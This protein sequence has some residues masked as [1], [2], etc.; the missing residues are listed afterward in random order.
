MFSLDIFDYSGHLICPI[1]TNDVDSSGQATDVVI[2][3]QRNGAKNLS[4]NLPDKMINNNGES[5]DNFRIE[6]QKAD[7]LIRAYDS[8]GELET[9]YDSQG[10]KRPV[11]EDYYIISEPKIVHQNL[12]AM[13]SVTCEHCSALLRTKNLGLVFSDTEGN[14]VGTAKDIL[15]TILSDPLDNSEP[16]GTGWKIGYVENFY[17]EYDPPATRLKMR[18]LVASDRT[19]AFNLISKLA[20]LFE[21]KPLYH[22]DTHTV[23][24][25]HMNPFSEPKDDGLPDVSTADGVFELNYGKNIKNVT[26]TVNTDNIVTH[27]YAYG[28]YGDNVSKYCG[29]DELEH[30]EHYFHASNTIPAGTECMIEAED[31][32]GINRIRYFVP[33][34]DILTGQD[35]IWST[36]DYASMSYVWIPQHGQVGLAYNV[37]EQQQHS[38]T[39][40]SLTYVDTFK[41]KNLV[42]S[43][44]NFNYYADVGL[45]TDEHLQTVAGYQR[46]VAALLDIVN[47]SSARMS[48]HISELSN[49]IG[50]VDFVKLKNPLFFEDDGE[51]GY[52]RV[53]YEKVEYT[54]EYM[55]KEKDWFKWR[56]AEGFLTK[57]DPKNGDAS[58]LYIVRQY[59]DPMTFDKHYFVDE[60]EMVVENQKTVESKN[61]HAWHLVKQ[62]NGMTR[63]SMAAYANSLLT[64]GSHVDISNRP[65]I[66][67]SEMIS[68]GWTDVTGDPVALYSVIRGFGT[69]EYPYTVLYTPINPFGTVYTPDEAYGYIQYC[70]NNATSIAEVMSRDGAGLIMAVYDGWI[71]DALKYSYST[72]K[73]LHTF[74]RMYETLGESDIFNID[75]VEEEYKT[76][77]MD[78][79]YKYLVI[80]KEWE[81]GYFDD[82]SKV[83]LFSSNNTN[84]YIGAAETSYLTNLAS[85]KDST[86]DGTI[87]HPTY[88]VSRKDAETNGQIDTSKL[89]PAGDNADWYGWCWVHDQT[90]ERS[91]MYFSTSDRDNKLWI[92]V[93][94]GRGTP[95]APERIQYFYNWREKVLYYHANGAEGWYKYESP[96]EIRIANLFGIVL[97]SAWTY[98][99]NFYGYNQ[100]YKYTHNADLAAGNYT[101]LTPYGSFLCF[102]TTDTVYVTPPTATAQTFPLIYDTT[103]K[104]VQTGEYDSSTV[105]YKTET[106]GFTVAEYHPTNAA[107]G[108]RVYNNTHLDIYGNDVEMDGW[109]TTHFIR[110]YE[111]IPYYV[112]KTSGRI[113]FYTQNNRFISYIDFN[114]LNNHQFETVEN[115]YYIRLACND[116]LSD[117]VVH[118]YNY[119]NSFIFKEKTYNLLN[120]IEGKGK[121]KGIIP[122]VKD[123][124]FLADYIYGSDD[125]CDYKI[126]KEAQDAVTQ[127]ENR[128]ADSLGYMYRD[129]WWQKN[130]Y[131]DGDEQKLYYDAMKTL[132]H[133]A[134]PEEKYEIGFLDT[135][136]SQQTSLPQNITTQSAAHLVDVDTGISKWA[137]IDKISRCYDQPWK[138]SIAINTNLTVMSQHTFADVLQHIAEVAN[139]MSGNDILYGRA[140]YVTSFGKI[141]ANQIEGQLQMDK[142][143]ITSASSTMYTDDRGNWVFEASDG[144]SAMMITGAG[145]CLAS[146]KDDDGEWVWRTF[147]TGEGFSADMITSGHIRAG[148]IE[149]GTI[150][151]SML[152]APVGSELELYGNESVRI[153]T[154]NAIASTEFSNGAN[155]LRASSSMEFPVHDGNWLIN[156]YQFPNNLPSAITNI[157]FK[158]HIRT[159]VGSK[160]KAAVSFDKGQTFISDQQYIDGDGWSTITAKIP[161]GASIVGAYIIFEDSN[162]DCYYHSPKLEYG[163]VS[164]AYSISQDDIDSSTRNLERA[165][166]DVNPKY[167]SSSVSS[168]ET[169]GSTANLYSELYDTVATS[170][171]AYGAI[172]K[173]NR[174]GVTINQI[175]SNSL[176]YTIRLSKIKEVDDYTIS[177]NIESTEAC[178]ITTQIN[179]NLQTSVVTIAPYELT[180]V[181]Y[182][183]YNVSLLQTNQITFTVSNAAIV[184]IDSL[185][186]EKGPVASA[187]VSNGDADSKASVNVLPNGDFNYYLDGGLL[188][189]YNTWSKVTNISNDDIADAFIC[190]KNLN[191]YKQMLDATYVSQYCDQN[192]N[193]L[194]VKCDDLTVDSSK[195]IG[196]K[197]I[198][199]AINEG[200]HYVLSMYAYALNVTKIVIQIMENNEV[201]IA[202]EVTNIQQRSIHN[203]NDYMRIEVPFKAKTNSCD[204]F[205]LAYCDVGIAVNSIA[206]FVANCKLEQGFFATPFSSCNLDNSLLN[207]ATLEELSNLKSRV[208]SAEFKVSPENII[209]T[210]TQ[211]DE[212]K[213]GVSQ[214]ASTIV[215]QKAEGITTQIKS[216]NSTLKNNNVVEKVSFFMITQEG[217]RI[218]KSDSN[219]S[220]LLSNERLSFFDNSQEVAYISNNTLSIT[221][222]Q[223]KQ[224]LEIGDLTA[225]VYS[226]GSVNIEWK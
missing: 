172:D 111:N 4:F 80:N 48:D 140:K 122:L 30:D 53:V 108:V 225:Y 226:D 221:Q 91:A 16:S 211:S 155:L 73:A 157:S 28:S 7:Y 143:K 154:E 176:T 57:G 36:L 149:S 114:A 112:N 61:Y 11:Y 202:K 113:C 150:V 19:G 87:E 171:S 166:L 217:L 197:H 119:D 65:E 214:E 1:Y 67:A 219:F 152:A 79:T 5:V 92:P 142:L 72:A 146:S 184:T 107:E 210:V 183:A 3:T 178:T 17:E 100:Q 174:H 9:A 51:Q 201:T 95:A 179:N 18:T 26:K 75:L 129:G 58:V 12:S 85:L 138:T 203:L 147:G 78:G 161:S 42:S 134:Y 158:V 29:I 173:N 23:D 13:R 182:P 204:I 131:V 69:E 186:V 38:G 207:G 190:G 162:T 191:E 165:I 40:I 192:V 175:G 212:F 56:K 213:N 215:D 37:Y 39:P 208:Q 88:F 128:M 86:K 77:V 196:V 106:K 135:R 32:F 126:L 98:S 117:L 187:W 96:A 216:I 49:I 64:P 115:T 206:L 148:L 164:T 169:F 200:S 21:A 45:F 20:D 50:S 198:P 205:I 195:Y 84:G 194:V 101:F 60:G 104:D 163:E 185:L 151:T 222:A 177:F 27:L 59:A 110:V 160:A 99:K 130:D 70:T 31:Y 144:S 52:T 136:E 10:L 35:I 170:S 116:D 89:P 25:V 33:T 125:W 34:Y 90:L 94:F 188:D 83:F 189:N 44:M 41:V 133:I 43:L 6:Y 127:L 55:K 218:K 139:T 145:F 47:K 54:T 76:E 109:N 68:K 103:Y 132:K 63:S 8:E 199:I 220:I 93:E 181:V 62:A 167:I 24:L 97:D 224:R 118:A 124:G 14:N 66:S 71:Y 156:N 46:N 105:Q 15:A 102:T 153:I 82:D 2:T 168:E 180:R 193:T 81:D 223:I 209:S 74:M 123:F 159:N 137:F 22:G 121:L 120:P 141:L